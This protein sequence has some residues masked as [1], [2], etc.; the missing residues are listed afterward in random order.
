MSLWVRFEYQKRTHIGLLEKHEIRFCDT[1]D[2]HP[3]NNPPPTDKTVNL[4]E[5]SLLIPAK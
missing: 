5:V 2:E 3:F 1:E 4:D